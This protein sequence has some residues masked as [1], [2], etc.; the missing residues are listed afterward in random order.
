MMRS[1]TSQ[2][3]Q[4][5]TGRSDPDSLSDKLS[6]QILLANWEPTDEGL[7][8]RQYLLL[9]G[10][11]ILILI[12]YVL[13]LWQLQILNGARYRYLSENN[14]VRL[15]EIPAPRGIIFDRHGIPL[16]E[17]RPAYHLMLVRE[18]VPDLD[19]TLEQVATICGNAP[20][21]L[22]KIVEDNKATRSFVPLRLMADIDRDC[23]ARL[24]ARRLR[25][26]GVFIR[27]EPRREY[28]FNGSAAHVI[29]YLSEVSE[30]EL[31]KDEYKQYAAGE[32][33]GKIGVERGL[34]PYLHG[35][36]GGRQVEVDAVGRRIR[37]L[38]ETL[39]I[40]GRNL[41][42]TID[43][44]LQRKVESILSDHIG[45]IVAL[46]PKSGS[47]LAMASSPT[48]DQER[49]V[50]GLKAKDWNE[51]SADPSHPLLNRAVNAAY[52]PGSTYKPIME[53]AGL[54]E[55]A[56]NARS[57]LS[58]PGFFRF[59]DRNYRCWKETGHGSVDP[60]RAI[61]ESC[62]V[63]F[64]QLGMKLG[65]DR[66]AR[67][68]GLFGLGEKSGVELRPESPGLIPTSE[69]KKRAKGVAWQKGETISI[70]IGQGFDLATPLQMAVAYA[71]I[72]NGGT[73]WQPHVVGRI[74]G[75]HP[76]DVT[77]VGGRVRR[78][79]PVAPEYFK[80]VQAALAGVVNEDR[81]TAKQIRMASIRIA[82]KTGTAQVVRMPDN[83]SR[84]LL[85]RITKDQE[86]DHAWFVSYAPAEDPAI[87]V[88]VLVEHGGHGSS[89][90][91]PL[92]RQVIAA[93]IE[94]EPNGPAQAE[95][96]PVP[97]SNHR[98]SSG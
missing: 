47:I 84:K 38:S 32:S 42:L 3:G 30:E 80:M 76:E 98:P 49:F 40:P 41:W 68:A 86:R 79:I 36:S 88:S 27:V 1:K 14:R 96:A 45:A 81:G 24:E 63:F 37:L 7:F 74:E 97:A 59:A 62:D 60:H 43:A 85:A 54:Q 48:F 51:M 12:I 71:A 92:A 13:R 5:Q 89:T 19:G 11:L 6:R 21:E 77:E 18:D 9:V 53:L 44:G 61:V 58:C 72:A 15:E 83:V 17:N 10:V 94:S 95:A 4:A 33:V 75:S 66:I 29:G 73:L 69:W 2:P 90:A 57:H 65:V 16:V 56:I 46:D 34:E 8:Q 39:P 82:G 26:P 22:R 78:K 52:P 91:A 87:V 67:Y 31:K 64:Y 50:R 20:D 70:S 25:L 93:Y 23:L 55:G 28:K 35:K